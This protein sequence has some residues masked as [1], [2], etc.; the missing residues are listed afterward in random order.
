MSKN[1]N[2]YIPLRNGIKNSR[3]YIKP[4]TSQGY[5]TRQEF[6]R[7]NGTKIRIDDHVYQSTEVIAEPKKV[8]SLLEIIICVLSTLALL[9]FVPNSIIHFSP[10]RWAIAVFLPFVLGLLIGRYRIELQQKQADHF[11]KS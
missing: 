11:N 2:Y 7:Y 8:H 3:R 5:K 6:E 4:I 10:A 1:L 9:Y